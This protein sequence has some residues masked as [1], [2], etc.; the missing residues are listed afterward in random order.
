M[1]QLITK[2]LGRKATDEIAPDPRLSLAQHA[3][4]ATRPSHSS[5]NK[6]QQQQL[7]MQGHLI[8]AQFSSVKHVIFLA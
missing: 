6:L 3:V 1:T 2:P 7:P 5:D 4:V 8:Q